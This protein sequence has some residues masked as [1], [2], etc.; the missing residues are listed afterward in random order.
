MPIAMATARSSAVPISSRYDILPSR[1]LLRGVAEHLVLAGIAW[2]R[3]EEMAVQPC[4]EIV[5]RGAPPVGQPRFA[6]V[7]RRGLRRVEDPGGVRR[8]D[9]KS[10]RLNS[11]HVRISYAVFC[12]KKK[13]INLRRTNVDLFS[14]C[15]HQVVNLLL[16][17]VLS[18]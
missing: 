16:V 9:R 1:Q 2:H 17:R 10:T 18:E 3:R 14:T 12:L 7:L 11:S 8:R 5:E 6:D 13:I 15:R 4:D